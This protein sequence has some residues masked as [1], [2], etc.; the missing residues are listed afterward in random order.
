M[1]QRNNMKTERIFV[2]VRDLCAGYVNN[3]DTNEERGVYAY[4]GKLCV[5]PE[6]QRSFVYD[7]EQ[8]NAVIDTALANLPLSIMYW[9]DNEDGT[10]DCLDGQQ[11]TISLCDFISGDTTQTSFKANW[12]RNGKETYFDILE[13]YD[14]DLAE[15]LLDYEIEVYLCRGTKRERLDWFNRIN[16]AGEKLSAQEIR[17]AN[18]TS[19]WLTDAKRYFSRASKN[20]TCPAEALF[21]KYSKKDANR[22]ELLEQV[23]YWRVNDK[24]DEAICAYMEQHMNDADASDLWNYFNE[25]VAWT[26]ANFEYYD[27]GFKTVEWGWLYN[28]YKDEELDP[29]EIVELLKDLLNAK[30]AKELT[31]T[32]AAIVEYCI[33]KNEQLLTH[34][35]FTDSQ[36][37]LLYNRQKGI[38]PDCGQPFAMADMH[39]HHIKSWRQGGVTEPANGVM[40]C[41]ECHHHRHGA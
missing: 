11:R 32:K 33:T 28:K 37:K 30:T 1:F 4:G 26:K 17:N 16:I 15:A 25:V 9:V 14:P 5:R 23:I 29:N 31:C 7:R 40:L 2:K 8:A 19:V 20:G 13:Q 10:Y 36:R 21:K 12:L 39:A 24:S 18:H 27:D 6:F 3:S 22:Q 38:C 41:T 35:K 34:R